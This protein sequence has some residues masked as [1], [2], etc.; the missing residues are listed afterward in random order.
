[1]ISTE[2]AG[3]AEYLRADLQRIA[4]AANT[5][6]KVVRQGRASASG[7]PAD[8]LRVID[9]ARAR[10]IRRVELAAGRL[11]AARD[12]HP[13]GQRETH[14][15][16]KRGGLDLDMTQNIPRVMEKGPAVDVRRITN[17]VREA[18]LAVGDDEPED[19]AGRHRA[20]AG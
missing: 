13:A 8:A 18:A 4:D 6:L 16:E 17:G 12:E 9:D 19:S 7:H 11:H 14:P 3:L 2:T 10:A 15:P 5:E 1:M 20:A